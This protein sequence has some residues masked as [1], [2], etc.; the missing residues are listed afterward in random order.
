MEGLR[1]SW[2]NGC[3]KLEVDRSNIVMSSKV[4]LNSINLRK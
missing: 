2:E 3:E 4:G 1:I